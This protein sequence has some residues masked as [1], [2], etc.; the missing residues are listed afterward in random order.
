[1]L[2]FA[3]DNNDDD[4][5]Y[6]LEHK[7]QTAGGIILGSFVDFCNGSCLYPLS[8]PGAGYVFALRGFRF[9]YRN[10]D[11]HMNQIGILR[12]ATGVRTYFNDSNSD[13]PYVAY[14]DYAW[15][16]PALV[17]RTGTVTGTDDGAGVQRAVTNANRAVISGFFVDYV[18]GGD[19]H[20]KELGVLTRSSDVQVYFGDDNGDD[21]FTYRVNYSV[22]RSPLVVG[23]VADPSLAVPAE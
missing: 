23:A 3:D 21:D 2:A 16:P 4:Y 11:H 9:Y 22:L 15:L 10:G 7:E 17:E 12:E 18:N 1:M 8:S 19:H 6:S 20:V 5:Y 13:D 14:V